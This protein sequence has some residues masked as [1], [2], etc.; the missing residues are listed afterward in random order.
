MRKRP[1]RPGGDNRKTSS[2]SQK[3]GEG[4]S[5]ASSKSQKSGEGGSKASEPREPLGFPLELES[6]RS[7]SEAPY[8]K[9]YKE[10]YQEWADETNAKRVSEGKPM[11]KLD[12]DGNPVMEKDNKGQLR[13]I[14]YKLTA[15]NVFDAEKRGSNPAHFGNK[16]RNVKDLIENYK[17]RREMGNMYGKSRERY[18]KTND[19]R[20]LLDARYGVK[21]PAKRKEGNRVSEFITE[22]SV[23][24]EAQ[25][26]GNDRNKALQDLTQDRLHDEIKKWSNDKNEALQKL[27]LGNLRKN[28]TD[29]RAFLREKFGLDVPIEQREIDSVMLAEAQKM[30]NERNKALRKLTKDELREHD[31]NTRTFLRDNFGV[32][33]PIEKFKTVSAVSTGAKKMG[34]ERNKALQ[35]LTPDDLPN[36][37]DTRTFLRDNFGV[38]VPIEQL[39]IDSIMLA[40]AK[41]IGNAENEEL[42]KRTL[43]SLPNETRRFLHDNFGVDVPIEQFGTPSAMLAEAQKRSNKRNE[44]LQKRTLDSLRDEIKINRSSSTQ[45]RGTSPAQHEDS[46]LEDFDLEDE[47]FGFDPEGVDLAD[48]DFGIQNPVE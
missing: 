42:Q 14:S 28:K 36:E 3:S 19:L 15:N 30:G 35:E 44:E 1:R 6:P 18:A 17:K 20:R 12:A 40:K 33:V 39:K 5:K 29:I 8:I 43:D 21:V 9:V 24:A 27:N 37:I 32:D 7:D 13:P 16:S 48:F 25:K 22:S 26:M 45:Q 4:G 11:Q 46:D 41:R 31:S 23:M 47:D 38:D 34:K 10:H 2:K